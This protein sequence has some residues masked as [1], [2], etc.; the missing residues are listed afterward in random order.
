MKTT[1]FLLSLGHL[2]SAGAVAAALLSAA[3]SDDP[4]ME[5]AP[6]GSTL[7]FEVAEADGWNAQPQ[8]RAAEDAAE[9][10]VSAGVFK[11][12]GENPADTLFLHA[13][14]S[15]GI[16]GAPDEVQMP[17]TRGV[18]VGTPNFYDSFGVMASVYTGSWNETSCLPDYMYNVEVTK[19]SAW[20]TS[21]RWP[22]SG[23]NIRFFAYAPYDAE[24]IVL[25]DMTT[26]GTPTITYTV[27]AEATRQKDLLVAVSPE[28]AGNTGAPAPL[29]FR[30]ALTAVRFVTG[31]DMLPGSITKIKLRFVYNSGT[32]TMGS[33]SW[34]PGSRLSE[35]FE[36]TLSSAADGSA[37]QEITPAEATFM[38]LPQ[39][40]PWGAVIEV[41]YA[42]SLTGTPRTMR[43]PIG[44]S[45]WP[46]GKTV[47]YRISTSNIEIAPTFSVTPP[48]A[49]SMKGGNH[50]YSVTSYVSVS[51]PLDDSA[52]PVPRAAKAWIAEFVEDD[53]AGGYRV[54]PKPDWLTD[55][56]TSGSGS[57]S[58]TGSS[59]QAIVAPQGGVTLNSHTDA[60]RAA[61]PV[62][63]TY[64]LATNGGTTAM[65]TANCY[66]VNAPGKYSLPL[67]YG[68]AVTNGAANS[69]AY[70]STAGGPN[71]L[72]HFVNHLGA[73]VTDPYIYNNANCTPA[74]AT[75]VWQDEKDLITNVALAAGGRSLT[76]EV[77]KETIQQ[78]NAIVAVRDASN[79]IMWSWHIWVTDY[80]LGDDIKTVTNYQNVQYRM[81]PVNLGW[82]DSGTRIYDA[83]S[84]KVRFTQTDT[85]LT[86][87]ITLNQ[88]ER[89]IKAEGNNPYFQFGRKD[90]MLPVI[91]YD[92]GFVMDVCYSD[93]YP[94]TYFPLNM[95]D[96]G[97]SIQNPNMVYAYWNPSVSYYNLWS[98]DNTVTAANDNAVVK[99][100]YD[101]SPAGYCLPASNAFT[102]FTYHGRPVSNLFEQI[103]SS[104]TSNVEFNTNFGWK[105]Y[106]NKMTGEGSYDPAGDMVYFPAV[107][108][109]DGM[110]R[111]INVR[112][113]FYVW[114]ATPMSATDGYSLSAYEN[115]V[116]PLD[117]WDRS[118]CV[119]VR[120][121]RE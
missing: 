72:T 71:V 30:H 67:V 116:N 5:T 92:N 14:I 36:Q 84:V 12:Q 95:C 100:I 46:I 29:T 62:S 28:M 53:G 54:I 63:G 13:T 94:F 6:R 25:S 39:T 104:Y 88:T 49:F 60:L 86:Q 27:P 44:R 26:A 80:K 113:E 81:L 64:D 2:L 58:D 65:N 102:G 103:N 35:Y 17:G 10:P 109:R 7:R 3:C 43:A 70:T 56:T 77:S 32:Y 69:S 90:P 97:S 83:R 34:K 52:L 68:N 23:R 24:G 4:T 74:D 15:D 50:T 91:T 101:P 42:D 96:I 108:S 85:G 51:H 73:A 112:Q 48:A 120:P 111:V 20:T 9:G 66:V 78:G 40:L 110:G 87:V 118:S 76:F 18:S 1:R 21:Y 59:F 55:F 41:C 107:G 19:A 11:L 57:V 82:C 38:M 79:R 61:I 22:G 105:F 114:S 106:C 119:S 33:A 93:D 31:D 45:E 115:T 117:S 47:T 89:R 16:V 37:D 75:L 8:S 99:T 121:V 98:A